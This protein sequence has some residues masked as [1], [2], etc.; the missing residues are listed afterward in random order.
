MKKLLL[1]FLFLVVSLAA[2]SQAI[3]FTASV[4]HTNG[5]PSGAPSTQ[6]SRL[7]YDK[8]NQ[9]L[10][11]WTGST[12]ARVVGV[13]TDGD[14]GD[15]TVSSS[16]TNW[17]LD[18]GSVGNTEIAS[19]AGGIYKGSGT[20]PASTV[21]TA[22]SGFRM[23]SGASGQILLGDYG[24]AGQGGAL[25]VQSSGVKLNAGAYEFRAQADDTYTQM[26][27]PG[28]TVRLEPTTG[29]TL[30]QSGAT[31]GYKFWDVR[32]T[33]RGVEYSAD[34]SATYNDRSLP[35]WGSVK[36]MISD[37]IATVG[38]GSSYSVYT[39]LLSQ[40]GTSAPTATV[41]QNTL[42][43]SITWTRSE[44]GFY[45]GALTSGFTL[46]KTW[47]SVTIDKQN[48]ADS[49]TYAYLGW[50]GSDEVI[51]RIEDSSHTLVDQFNRASIEIRVYP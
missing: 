44:A 3:Q 19:G 34:Y 42:S 35:D 30:I 22:T 11:Q 1:F 5:T 16:G 43:G 7:R 15:I 27:S 47:L 10:Y 9:I 50:S 12:W 26:V 13:I 21:A 17:Q 31:N 40:S 28:Y 20:I 4:P 6:G 46:N 29:Y 33:P 41:L 23:N 37:S 51:L 25:D 36:A 24:Y 14:K 38:G 45:V 2:R 49:E 48:Q 18:A 32:A 8:T 39:A